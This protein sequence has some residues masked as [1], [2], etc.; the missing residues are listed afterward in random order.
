MTNN[1]KPK[2]DDSVL[3]SHSKE[4][5]SVPLCSICHVSTTKQK[6]GEYQCPTCQ[7]TYNPNLEIL[8]YPDTLSSPHDDEHAELA[9]IGGTGGSLLADNEDSAVSDLYRDRKEKR[10][11]VRPDENVIEYSE[12]I[13]SPE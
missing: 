10:L 11:G 6:S 3:L 8:E 1:P 7:R 5:A 13:P 2:E 4:S 9:G 12:Y